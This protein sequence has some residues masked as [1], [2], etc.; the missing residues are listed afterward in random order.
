VGT[1]SLQL[2][3]STAIPRFSLLGLQVLCKRLLLSECG[4]VCELAKGQKG[5]DGQMSK[6]DDVIS[7]EW[8]KD[9]RGADLAN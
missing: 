9:A 6:D 7:Q 8:R 1:Y 2:A 4:H 3:A 5:Q